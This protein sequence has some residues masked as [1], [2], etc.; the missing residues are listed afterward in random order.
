MVGTALGA[1]RLWFTVGY[2]IVNEIYYPRVDIPQIRDLGFIVAD[3]KGFWCE[4]KR[5]PGCTI[6]TAAPGVPAVQI[7]HRHARF[8]LALRI[9]ADPERDVLLVEARLSG[10][11]DLK[12]YALLAP[13]LGGTGNGN[14]AD[15][16]TNRSRVVL[17][18]EQGPFALA[19]AAADTGQRDAWRRASAGYVGVSDGWQDFSHNGSMTWGY[20]RAGPGNVALT[21]ELERHSVLALGFASSKESAATLALSSL[22]QPFDVVWHRYIDAWTAWQAHRL[23]Q[24]LFPRDFRNELHVSAM[25]LKTHQDKTYPGAMVASLSIPWGNASDDV[26]GYHLVWPRDLVQSAGAL[27]AIGA[28][29]EARDTLRYLIATQLDDG[30]WSQN[31]W[32]GGTPRWVG[33]QLDEVAFPVLLASALAERD[34]LDGFVVGGMVSRALAYLVREGPTSGQDRWEEDAGINAYTLAAAI[35][36]LVC[37]AALLDDASMHDVLLIADDWNARIEEWCSASGTALS[38][39]FGIDRYYVRAAPQ[40]VIEDPRALGDVIPIKNCI[41]DPALPAC[42]QIST[43]FLQLVRFG[44]RRPDDPVVRNTLRLVDALLKADTPQG[45]AWYR[46]NGDGYGEHDG[47]APFDGTGRGRPWP[48]LAGERGHYAL[49]AGEDAHACLRAMASMSGPLGLISEQVWDGAPVPRYGLAPGKPSGSAMPLVWAHAEFVKLACS[50]RAGYPVDRPSALWLRYGGKTPHAERSHW[51]RRARVS[52]IAQ[53]QTLRL[54]LERL[55]LVHYG[56]GG[57]QQPRDL[58]TTEGVLG[59]HVVDLP[60]AMMAPGDTLRFALQDQP[61]KRWDAHE[62][63]VTVREERH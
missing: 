8:E 41:E 44:L 25:V 62:Y 10:D 39:R 28:V 21:A 20:E 37:G 47:G 12:P 51:T 36:A 19:L 48:L 57:W 50:L 18:A 27:L 7:L 4:V 26:G 45:A 5:N 53:G 17:C 60:T 49:L 2:G 40:R 52:T 59:L 14:R 55:T 46:Y 3:G 16:F 1:S 6:A 23:D 11:A 13:H 15:V 9:V 38:A 54:M 42:H 32:L 61:S 58:L 34:A 22:I 35:A 30:R 43:D 56:V 33:I 63:T 31:Q 24:N 29:D